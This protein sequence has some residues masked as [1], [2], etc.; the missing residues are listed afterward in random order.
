MSRTDVKTRKDERYEGV[1]HR[2]DQ[3]L[4]E[5]R[6]IHRKDAADFLQ[7][8]WYHVPGGHPLPGDPVSSVPG[9]YLGQRKDPSH[10]QGSRDQW[11]PCSR[12][13]RV[14]PDPVPNYDRGDEYSHPCLGEKDKWFCH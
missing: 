13:C 2:H 8:L 12:G 3:L 10:P 1:H 14:I 9:D 11:W 4:Q 7:H 5:A 6:K